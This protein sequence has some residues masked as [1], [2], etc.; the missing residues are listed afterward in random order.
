MKQITLV[1]ALFAM[2]A[3]SANAQQGFAEKGT[4]I[5]KIGVGYA[6]LG[7]PVEASYEKSIK[8]DFLGIKKFNLAGGGYLGYFG[9]KEK[10]GA[11]AGEEYGWKYTNIIVGARAIGHYQFFEKIDT[12]TGIMLGYNIASLKFYGDD[13]FNL[14]SP[15]AG[16]FAWAGM[17]GARYKFNKTTGIYV[18][19][20]AGIANL[21]VGIAFNL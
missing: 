12:Y 18:E 21:T 6:A 17:V 10:V 14:D 8:N 19:G 16:G 2:V 4:S 11:W 7:F 9:Y 1:V 15:S 5:A 3:V 20:G 13:T